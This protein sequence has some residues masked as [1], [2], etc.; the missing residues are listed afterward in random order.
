[1]T[2]SASN[3]SFLRPSGSRPRSSNM[4]LSGLHSRPLSSSS[5]AS[6]FAASMASTA[7]ASSSQP[8]RWCWR[9]EQA[10]HQPLPDIKVVDASDRLL[11]QVPG[12][13]VADGRVLR[14]A[15]IA[16]TASSESSSSSSPAFPLEEQRLLFA[17]WPISCG[18][19]P[20]A[21]RLNADAPPVKVL[22][23]PADWCDS[24]NRIALI[25]GA[26]ASSSDFVPLVDPRTALHDDDIKRLAEKPFALV[27]VQECGSSLRLVDEQLRDASV[28]NVGVALLF[29]SQRLRDDEGVVRAAIHQNGM[30]LEYASTRLRNDRCLVYQA[31][32]GSG[33]AFA[34]CS[35]ACR[36]DRCL[37]L[38]AVRKSAEAI[39]HVSS[40]LLADREFVI[41]ALQQN[42]S[43]WQWLPPVFHY[44]RDPELAK[45][46]SQFWLRRWGPHDD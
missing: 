1:M 17:G 26:G 45:I 6:S 38:F 10:K 44:D 3:S 37:A 15:I 25:G 13:S 14:Q 40:K 41:E 11:C 28:H 2:P 32:Q 4:R 34:F 33:A 19:L 30:A 39:S 20:S 21:L 46:V 22:R 36:A 9:P 5:F 8:S 35:E 7:A 42:G 24:L 18:P 29:A 43:A 27:A 23:V 16:E 31:L 12:A